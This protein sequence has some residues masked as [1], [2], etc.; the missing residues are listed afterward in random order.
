MLDDTDSGWLNKGYITYTVFDGMW[1]APQ[2]ETQ[3]RQFAELIV[4]AP[5]AP[6]DIPA[7]QGDD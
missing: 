7:A 6:S 4:V 3:Y 5:P 2:Y 1:N